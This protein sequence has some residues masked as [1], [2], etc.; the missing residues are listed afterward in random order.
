MRLDS[1]TFKY[2]HAHHRKTVDHFLNILERTSVKFIDYKGD[3]V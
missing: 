1:Y 2:T 3:E